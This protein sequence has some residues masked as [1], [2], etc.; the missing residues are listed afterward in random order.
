MIAA[1]QRKRLL[2]FVSGV[3]L[4]GNYAWADETPSSKAQATTP[5]AGYDAKGKRDPFSPLVREG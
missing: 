4:L 3:L 2:L 1:S 5:P